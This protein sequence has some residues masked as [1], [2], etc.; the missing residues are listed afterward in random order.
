MRRLMRRNSRNIAPKISIC[1]NRDTDATMTKRGITQ[2]GIKFS[3]TFPWIFLADKHRDPRLPQR[4]WTLSV[5]QQLA[6]RVPRDP[7][8]FPATHEPCAEHI[9]CLLRLS[10]SD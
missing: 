7:R 3:P 1:T 10:G 6:C 2:F 8:L 5:G 9:P 4:R